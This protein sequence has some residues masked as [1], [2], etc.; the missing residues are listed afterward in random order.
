MDQSTFREAANCAATQEHPSILW[1]PKVHYRVHKSSPPVPILSQIN[2]V[3]TTPSYLRSISILSTHLR[4]GLPRF[5]FPSGFPINILYSYRFSPFVLHALS[6]SS[7]LTWSFWLYLA[8]S[9][10]YEA[11]HYAVLSNLLSLYLFGPNIPLSTLSLC[12]SVNVTD[13]V[14]QPYRSTGKII[15]WYILIF[16]FLD[17]R[18][19]DERF[20]TE[21]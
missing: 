5:L 21:W 20:W 8:K 17:S 2:P 1:N 7:S 16:M 9:T 19:E 6:S 3:H 4:L 12:S 15:V 10:S 14:S 11:L 18:R 13:R